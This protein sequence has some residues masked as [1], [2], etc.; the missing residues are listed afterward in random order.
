MLKPL[1]S[2]SCIVS[3]RSLSV[4]KGM[5]GVRLRAAKRPKSGSITFL[6]PNKRGFPMGLDHDV[7]PGSQ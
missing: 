4:V 7:K 3:A 6:F 2:I 5:G 1:R